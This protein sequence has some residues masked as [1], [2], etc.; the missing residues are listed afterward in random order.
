MTRLAGRKA[1][2]APRLVL[3][4]RFDQILNGLK[5]Y[6]NAALLLALPPFE[7]I[8]PSRQFLIRGEQPP[9]PDKGPHNSDVHLDG[10]LAGEDG[11]EHGNSLLRKSVGTVAPSAAATFV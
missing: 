7:L 5:D 6:L 9:E 1:N 3:R 11:R 8:Q 10:S 4:R 2:P